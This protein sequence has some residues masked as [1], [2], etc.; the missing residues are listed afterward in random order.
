MSERNTPITEADILSQVVAPDQADLPPEFARSIL[1][2]KF[3]QA[4]LD[5]MKELAGKNNQG[6][7]TEAERAEMEKYMRV[8]NF[9]DLMQAKA[10]LSLQTADS[11][12]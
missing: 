12:D 9:L 1:N 5:R 7:L 3:S 6:L 4:A 8:G 10:R 2:L 11:A